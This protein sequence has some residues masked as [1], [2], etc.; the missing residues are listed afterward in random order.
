RKANC[1]CRLVP[2][3]TVCVTVE[4]NLPNTPP[5]PAEADVKGCPGCTWFVAVPKVGLIVD[6]GL[7]KFGW[8]KRL[9]TSARN[10]TLTTSRIGNRLEIVRS[11][12]TKLGP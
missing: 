12:C 4:L 9:K 5:P 1:T 6:G 3:P 8:F 11:A 2:I 10:S 7:A